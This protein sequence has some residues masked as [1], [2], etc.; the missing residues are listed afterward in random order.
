MAGV[1][2]TR[3][4]RFGEGLFRWRSFTPVP[5]IAVAAVLVARN[6]GAAAPG[7]I[8]AGVTL[9]AAGQALRAWVL[10]QV[11]DGTSGQNERLIAT[12]LNTEGP[13][14]RTRNPLYL[15]NLL[16]TL[17]ICAC[18]HSAV[19]LAVVAVLFGIQYG[20]IIAAEE[21]FLRDRFGARFEA[22]CAR[23][24]RFWPQLGGAASAPTWSWRRALRKEHNPAAAW[25][26]L[27]LAL[28]AWDAVS[29]GRGAT[30]FL[31]GGALLAAGWLAVK[32]WKHRWLSGG[33]ASDLKR[34]IR[35]TAR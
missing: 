8:V 19:L 30:P 29:A 20:A 3:L 2:A 12:D 34:R 26:A 5:V 17:G 24:P 14:A 35:E 11:V 27:T 13:Y 7:W 18:A 22:Y 16:I 32:G 25:I 10:G 4:E 31:W 15:G 6:R 28:F 33:F 9:C 21:R 1:P 23:V